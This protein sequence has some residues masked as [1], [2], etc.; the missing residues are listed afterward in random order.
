MAGRI[1]RRGKKFSGN[2]SSFTQMAGDL[3][4][5]LER[6][7]EVKKISAGIIKT[8]LPNLQGRKRIKII[9]EGA[10]LLLRVRDN[11]SQQEVRVYGNTQGVVHIIEKYGNKKHIVVQVESVSPL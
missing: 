7:I 11:I 9:D 3:V 10:C 8:K 4:S 1:S 2:H 5:R 6:D